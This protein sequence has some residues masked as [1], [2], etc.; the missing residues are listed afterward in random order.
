MSRQVKYVLIAA[1]RREIGPLLKD[2]QRTTV[3][4]FGIAADHWVGHEPARLP[5]LSIGREGIGEQTVYRFGDAALLCAGPGYKNAANAARFAMETFSP[6]VLISIGFAGALASD[7][8]VGDIFIPRHI[9]SER[10]GSTF[11]MERGRG[12][13]LT[14]EGVVGVETKQVLGTRFHAQAADMEAAAVAAVA[15]TRNCECLAVK[16]ISDE[17]HAEVSFL[18]AFVRPEG[19]RMGPFLAHISVRPQLWPVVRALQRDSAV[20]AESLS[21]AVRVLSTQGTSALEGFYAPTSGAAGS[22]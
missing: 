12:S 20:A 16:A 21:R 3:H 8:K 6:E 18:G 1:L 5:K 22:F 15:A 10:T 7:L 4:P 13:L 2:C 9:I 19:F 11:T 14:S 17:L